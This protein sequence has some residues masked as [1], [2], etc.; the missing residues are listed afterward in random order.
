[1]DN[2]ELKQGATISPFIKDVIM[3]IAR[4][5]PDWILSSTGIEEARKFTVYHKSDT[6]NPLGYI[7][8][9]YKYVRG[10]RCKLFTIDNWRIAEMR[11]RGSRIETSKP[12]E[13]LKAV[14]KYFYPLT[15]QEY[16]NQGFQHAC[17]IVHSHVSNARHTLDASVRK[18]HQP[19]MTFAHKHWDT[20]LSTLDDNERSEALNLLKHQQLSNEAKA[21]YTDVDSKK[22]LT[23][24]L[25]NG[26]Y[27]VQQGE[28]LQDYESDTLPEHIKTKVGLLKLVEEKEVIPEVGVRV[29]N[30]YVVRP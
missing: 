1:V 21:L 19:M 25:T 17:H 29:G 16:T 12:K 3:E 7:N 6:S 22:C 27:T 30:L 13:A 15:T 18:L 26:K 14:E 20:F 2:I 23:V 24:L 5:H 10:E 4:K 28:V 9:D 11:Q 8:E